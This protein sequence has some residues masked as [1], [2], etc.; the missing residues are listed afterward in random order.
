[1]TRASAAN[2]AVDA[3]HA[4]L[5]WGQREVT[6]NA[7]VDGVDYARR[8]DIADVATQ[9]GIEYKTGYQT[10]TQDNLWEVTRDQALAQS[11][12]DIQW[13]FRDTASQPLQDALT[14][15]GIK[16]KFGNQ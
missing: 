1:M 16:F 15:A 13:V 5:G 7:N 4:N 10:A 9:R 2:E 3:Y 6:V 8:L 11:G 14:N 12:W